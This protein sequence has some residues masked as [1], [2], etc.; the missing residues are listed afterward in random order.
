MNTT[1][2]CCWFGTNDSVLSSA[3][4]LVPFGQIKKPGTDCWYSLAA[5][6]SCIT[7]DTKEGAVVVYQ[8]RLGSHFDAGREKASH[9][10]QCVHLLHR[11][12][13]NLADECATSNH[14]G[15]WH[16]DY[17]VNGK[18]KTYSACQ[19]N[20]KEYKVSCLH[21]SATLF[22][23]LMHWELMISARMHSV[24]LTAILLTIGVCFDAVIYF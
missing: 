21:L 15:C 1:V 4:V 8:P 10:C 6:C 19:D 22:V 23:L 7:R 14:A 5:W 2:L 17:K 11:C 3:G 18:T 16:K 24:H 9:V 12:L 20:V 13:S